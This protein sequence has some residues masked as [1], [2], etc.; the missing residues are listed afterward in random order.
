MRSGEQL[1]CVVNPAAAHELEYEHAV[2]LPQGERIAVIGAGP[3]GL[4]YA[5]LVAASNSVTVFDGASRAGGAL[6]VAGMA[7]RFQGVDA[8]QKSLDA[9]I[10]DLERACV[11]KNVV[12]RYRTI[13]AAGGDELRSFDRI[14]IATG[15]TYRLGLGPLAV[16]LLESGWGK[17]RFG[18]WLLGSAR[19]RNWFYYRAR[20][21]M[22]PALEN[23]EGRQIQIIG[24]AASPG[25]IREAIAS[26]FRA[27]LTAAG[28]GRS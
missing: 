9:Y 5:E 4:A 14:V 21:S 22:V 19:V 1:G 16:S 23:M 15:A 8:V 20:K 3:A 12:F 11:K 25:K 27:A 24:D 6:R 28:V 26:A 10:D 7:P 18:R 17:S 13:I 2:T